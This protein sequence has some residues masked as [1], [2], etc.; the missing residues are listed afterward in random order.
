MPKGSS[1]ST[2]V[3]APAGPL[4][5][6]A[7]DVGDGLAG[8][9]AECEVGA[10][11]VTTGFAPGRCLAGPACGF[12]VFFAPREPSIAAPQNGNPQ[13]RLQ[14]RIDRRMDKLEVT[15]RWKSAC[16]RFLECHET[17]QRHRSPVG[18]G[19]SLIHNRSIRE[20]VQ[21][22]GV[23]DS[24]CC[25]GACLKTPDGHFRPAILTRKTPENTQLIT[26]TI[27]LFPVSGT[28]PNSTCF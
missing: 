18:V 7:G 15:W 25:V 3:F 16:F 20:S 19:R 22:A 17:S 1:S 5:G 24:G 13:H 8:F 27:A 23:Q 21:F 6:R 2:L 14:E 10:G 28:A 11:G 9:E 12:G 26:K 4:A